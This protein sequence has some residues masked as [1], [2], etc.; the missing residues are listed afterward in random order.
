MFAFTIRWGEIFEYVDKMIHGAVNSW[1]N[2]KSASCFKSVSSSYESE[3]WSLLSLFDLICVDLIHIVSRKHGIYNF[4]CLLLNNWKYSL[5]ICPNILYGFPIND[6][7]THQFDYLCYI[8]RISPSNHY[9]CHSLQYS[10][11]FKRDAITIVHS[12]ATTIL[13]CFWAKHYISY[14]FFTNALL[15][16]TQGEWMFSFIKINNN[17]MI[18]INNLIM[19]NN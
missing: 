11:L 17:S 2:N 16:N 10:C 3:M 14:H 7:H 4:V 18:I 9:I 6:K 1:S 15:N 19:I 5:K 13:I 12:F 8:H